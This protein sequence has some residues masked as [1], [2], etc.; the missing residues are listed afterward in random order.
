MGFVH[1]EKLQDYFK[2][3]I[4]KERELHGAYLS[5][6]DFIQR[7]QIGNEQIKQLIYVGALRFTG[8]TKAE[9]IVEARMILAGEAPK[10]EPALF[11]TPTKE[12]KLPQ[13]VR[14]ALEDAY[15]EIDVLNFPV[16]LSTFD[17]LDTD[18]KDSI[19]VEQ[20]TQLNNQYVVMVGMLISIK[21]VPTNKGHMNFGTWTDSKGDY[22]D[23][24]HF[25][26]VLKNFP[27]KGGGCYA[28]Y[29]KV[30]IDFDFPMLEV[31]RMEKLPMKTDPRYDDNAH[32]TGL[33]KSHELSGSRLTRAPYPSQQ[34]VNKLYGRE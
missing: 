9:L 26:D 12:F 34:E 33:K 3:L 28:L 24:T 2:E 14:S 21:D 19:F 6:E 22:F 23:S 18:V 31:T 8:K 5:L 4:P 15:D 16:S 25:P 1:I 13:L 30:V 10:K 7:T 32:Q 20:L 27:F 11:T 17:L 29:G